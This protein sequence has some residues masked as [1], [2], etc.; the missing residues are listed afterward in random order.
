MT[1]KKPQKLKV[2]FSTLAIIAVIILLA[3][4]TASRLKKE[5]SARL[6]PPPAAG[7]ASKGKLALGRYGCA[8]C[9]FIPGIKGRQTMVGPPLT[10]LA[11]RSHI[12]AGILPNNVDNMIKWII[13]P[14]SINPKTTMP[15]VG[16]TREDAEDIAAFLYR[17][18]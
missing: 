4:S 12:A 13:D 7:D 2:V 10:S 9:H 18:D 8:A 15:N 6:V 14:P 5:T 1:N 16:V 11:Y 3:F 17:A